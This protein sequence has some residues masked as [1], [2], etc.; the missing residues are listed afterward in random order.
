MTHKK[1]LVV[2]DEP[3]LLKMV[4]LRLEAN[5]FEVFTA[6]DGAEGIIKARDCK[7][8]LIIVDVLMPNLDGCA[9]VQELKKISEIRSIPV[10]IFTA[11]PD[12]Q[13]LFKKEGIDYYI[14]KPYQPDEFLG[15]IKEILGKG[16]VNPIQL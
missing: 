11:R 1:I 6:S 2:D 15:K 3:D 9:F 14:I 13:D 4:K 8:D 10:I 12:L 16:K 7:P 5:E